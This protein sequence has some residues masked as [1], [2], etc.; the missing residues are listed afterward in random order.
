M[1]KFIII[2]VIIIIIFSAFLTDIYR[3]EGDSMSPD[4]TDGSYVL[5]VRNLPGFYSPEAGDDVVFRSPQSGRLNLKRCTAVDGNGIFVT[6][7]NLPESTDSRHF[8]R[9]PA[10][11]IEGWVWIKI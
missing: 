1:Q 10:E 3:V 7:V 5:T 9:I 6:G 4:F 8:G 2:S 11:D